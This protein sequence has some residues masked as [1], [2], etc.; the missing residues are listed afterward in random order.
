MI[1]Q[2]LVKKNQLK[3]KRSERLSEE[4]NNEVIE[5]KSNDSEF[6]SD[7]EDDDEEDENVSKLSKK[8]LKTTT[9]TS[10]QVKSKIKN[11]TN[12]KRRKS[13]SI[14]SPPKRKRI[15]YRI[16]NP[17]RVSSRSIRV[18]NS[19]VDEVVS[20]KSEDDDGNENKE[21]DFVPDSSNDNKSHQDL[22]SDE[23]VKVAQAFADEYETTIKL[24]TKSNTRE[25]RASTKAST[26]AS[27]AASISALKSSTSS[28]S[29]SSSFPPI[30]Q[31]RKRGRRSITEL[32]VLKKNTQPSTSL[33]VSATI[34]SSTKKSEV[35]SNRALS[36]LL[37]LDTVLENTSWDDETWEVVAKHA[38]KKLAQSILTPLKGDAHNTD[39]SSKSSKVC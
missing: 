29:S 8:K 5:H 11:N 35:P 2:F 3:R 31:K 38:A 21:P 25:T 10:T 24:S 20:L 30:Q 32:E 34:A 26:T 39:K 12:N 13:K 9:I 18:K 37:S 7:N 17:S 1:E 6:S 16:R 19:K 27:A 22:D 14:N 28:S 33:Q 23:D 36:P 15:H 4:D